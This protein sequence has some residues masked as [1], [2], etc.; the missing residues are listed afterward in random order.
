ML[1]ISKGDKVI[2]SQYTGADPTE[3]MIDN[4]DPTSMYELIVVTGVPPV[5]IEGETVY[6]QHWGGEA[7]DPSQGWRR[8]DA[9]GIAKFLFNASLDDDIVKLSHQNGWI[10]P[11][12]KY[13]FYVRE[14][15]N[16][17]PLQSIEIEIVNGE[18]GVAIQT[19]TMNKNRGKKK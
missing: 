11:A 14:F 6:K 10:I 9:N 3:F 4:G 19:V 17:K 7:N 8:P 18:I 15:H 13:L 5:P 1:T 12:G 16:N 2:V